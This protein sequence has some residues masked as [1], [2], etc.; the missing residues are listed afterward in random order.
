MFNAGGFNT[1]VVNAGS[2]NTGQRVGVGCAG[3]GVGFG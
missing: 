1:G 3:V 2:Y